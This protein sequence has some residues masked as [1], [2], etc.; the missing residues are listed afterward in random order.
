MPRALESTLNQAFISLNIFYRFH[1]FIICSIPLKIN[2]IEITISINPMSLCIILNPDLPKLFDRYFDILK[3]NNVINRTM[4]KA[5][6]KC[7]V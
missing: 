2:S 6:N 3:I 5:K 4:N 7:A 1:D